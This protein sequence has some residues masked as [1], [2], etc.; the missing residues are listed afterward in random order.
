MSFNP[1]TNHPLKDYNNQNFSQES[2]IQT[3]PSINNQNIEQR[4]PSQNQINRNHQQVPL[5]YNPYKQPYSQY[6]GHP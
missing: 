4:P 5:E 3:P 6:Q 2:N 1:I